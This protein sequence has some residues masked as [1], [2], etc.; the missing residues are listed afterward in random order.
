MKLQKWQ[1]TRITEISVFQTSSNYGLPEKKKFSN[2]EI[3]NPRINEILEIM[4]SNYYG[5]RSQVWYIHTHLS[6]TAY[7]HKHL[8]IYPSV[9]LPIYFVWLHYP[10]PMLNLKNGNR[11][12]KIKFPYNFTKFFTA[13]CKFIWPTV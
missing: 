10:Q 5:N 2:L 7:I 13:L 9:C 11:P 1:S 3:W 12:H 4:K 8:S 6:I